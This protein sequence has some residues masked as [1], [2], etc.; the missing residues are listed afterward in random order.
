MQQLEASGKLPSSSYSILEWEIFATVRPPDKKA[1][2]QEV[3]GIPD[4]HIF[5][6]RDLSLT[7][8]ILRMTKHSSGRDATADMAL[9]GAFW[10]VHRDWHKGYPR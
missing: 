4:N 7:K 8:G 3:Y 10:H 6:S 5:N 1:L 9:S 2:I